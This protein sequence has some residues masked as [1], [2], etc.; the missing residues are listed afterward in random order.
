MLMSTLGLLCTLAARAQNCD[1]TADLR[2]ARQVYEQSYAG[3]SDLLARRGAASYQQ[4]VD[5]LQQTIQPISDLAGCDKT[6]R[7]Y[8]HYFGD[9]H[10][11][12]VRTDAYRRLAGSS[13][14][15]RQK[16]RPGLE[17][18]D[19][20][21][22]LITIPSA[23]SSRQKPLDSLL[24]ANKALLA[25]TPDLLVDV[26]G[27][28]GG[29]ARVFLALLEL[30]YTQSVALDGVKIRSSP[31][32]LALYR[33]MLAKPG[34]PADVRKKMRK[35][36]ARMKSNPDGFVLAQAGR[37]FILGKHRVQTNPQRVSILID[38][39]CASATKEF[40]LAARQIKKVT[41][42]GQPTAGVLDHADVYLELL[43]SGLFAVS[44]PTSRSLRLPA[45]LFDPNGRTPDVPAPNWQFDWVCIS[46]AATGARRAEQPGS[47]AVYGVT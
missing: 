10:V 27:D 7:H 44:I 12:L 25:R 3:F 28:G 23:D 30:L 43:P 13:N 37:T 6:L 17:V 29:N 4:F 22:V 15:P 31:R 38:H 41:L 16:G 19:G 21:V 2:F 40:L 5:S 46:C 32:N 14:R 33:E 8:V 39:H 45:H 36:I 20:Q 42:F 18:L 34:L 24:T 11:N 35:V 26:R 47:G 9:G 1:C